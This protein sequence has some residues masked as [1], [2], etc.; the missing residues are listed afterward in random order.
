MGNKDSCKHCGKLHKL[1]EQ[2]HPLMVGKLKTGKI[3]IQADNGRIEFDPVL[4][5][6]LISALLLVRSRDINI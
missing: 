4:I 5:N 1:T 6:D 2:T 3:F